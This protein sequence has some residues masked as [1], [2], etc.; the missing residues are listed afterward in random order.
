MSWLLQAGLSNAAVAALLAVGV[1]ALSRVIRNPALVH[2]MW[3]VVLLKLITPPLFELPLPIARLAPPSAVEQRAESPIAASPAA[4]SPAAASP[5]TGESA[6]QSK[7]LDVPPAA[8]PAAPP[9]DP[10]NEIGTGAS[11]VDARHL[12]S[13]AGDVVVFPSGGEVVIERPADGGDSPE[14]AARRDV[15]RA[16]S[17]APMQTLAAPPRPSPAAPQEAAQDAKAADAAFAYSI[18]ADPQWQ[19][20]LVNAIWLTGAAV[21]LLITLTRAR[22]FHWLLHRSMRDSRELA[23]D[24]SK[25]AR[26]A[27]VRRPP[28]VYLVSGAVSPMLWPLGLRPA[29]LFPAKLAESL[30]RRSRETLLLHELAHY[31]RGDHWVRLLEVLAVCLHWWN[32]LVWWVRREVHRVEEDCCDAWVIA[33]RPESRSVYARALVEAIDFLSEAAPSL[34]PTACGIGYLDSVKRRLQRIMRGRASLGLS[35]AGKLIILVFALTLAPLLPTLRSAPAEEATAAEKTAAAEE[36]PAEKK[37]DKET[38][39]TDGSSPP[40]SRIAA[41]GG[42]SVGEA[43]EFENQAIV[44]LD[45]PA[46][47]RG[48]A[49]SPDGLVAASGGGEARTPGELVVWN[50][51]SGDEVFTLRYQRGVRS[52]AFSPDGKLL[53]AGTFNNTVELIQPATG[54]TVASLTDSSSAINSVAFSPDG[55]R[56]AAGSLDKA[57]RLY[58]TD[59]HE[60]VRTLNGHTDWVFFVAFSPDGKSLA[61]CGRDKTLRIWNLET[62]QLRRSIETGREGECTAFSPDGKMVAVALWDGAVKLYNAES[63]DV[64]ATLLYPE[65]VDAGLAATL[66]F[67]PD[68]KTLLAAGA[69]QTVKSWDLSTFEPVSEFKAHDQMVWALAVSADGSRLLTGGDDRVVKLWNAA[70]ETPLATLVRRQVVEDRPEPILAIAWSAD[71]STIATSHE[72]LTIRLRDADSGALRRVLRGHDDVASAI[73]FSPDGTTLASGAADDTVRLWNV[74]TGELVRKLEGHTNWVFALAFSH[75]GKTLA[76]GGY[77]KTIR[78]WDAA[79]GES[80]ASL[81]GHDAAV[82]SLSFSP[83]DK[84]L[85][86]GSSDRSV[87]LWDLASKKEIGKLLGHEGAVRGVAFSP[88][89]TLLASGS[90]DKTVKLWNPGTKAEVRSLTGHGDMVW[91]LA[92]SAGGSTLASGGF[93]NEIKLWDPAT[94]ALRQTLRGHSEVVASLSFAPDT[95]ALASA[96]YD[97]TIRL[98]KSKGPPLPVA[99]ALAMIHG[100]GNRLLTIAMSPDA[101]LLAAAGQDKTVMLRDLRSGK[102]LK[103][104]AGLNAPISDIE[105]SPDGRTLAV[106]TYGTKLNLSLW[107]VETS[108]KRCDLLGHSEGVRQVVFSSDGK[109]LASCGWDKTARIWDLKTQKSLHATPEQSLP[110][111]GVAFSPDGETF[112]T[113]TGNWKEW[114]TPGEVKLWETKTGRELRTLGSHPHEVKGVFFEKTGNH[115]VSFGSGAT[116]RWD[117][118]TNEEATRL[119]AGRTITAVASFPD[120]RQAAF[121]DTTGAITVFD[122][123]TGKATLQYAG[124]TELVFAVAC[125]ADGSLLASL[126]RDGSIRLWPTAPKGSLLDLHAGRYVVDAA[127]SPDGESVLC[128]GTGYIK[129]FDLSSGSLIREFDAPQGVKH[130]GIAFTPNG[131]RAVSCGSDRMVRVWDVASGGELRQLT[132]HS[133]ELRCVA[134]SPDGSQAATGGFDKSIVIWDLNAGRLL[135]RLEGHRRSIWSIA[136]SPDGK[137]IASGGQLDA[138]LWDVDTGNSLKTISVGSQM[139]AITFSAD[140]ESL[141]T[142]QNNAALAQWDVETGELIW[143]KTAHTARITGACATPDGRHL[144][145][146]GLDGAVYKWDLRDDA[147]PIRLATHSA[148]SPEKNRVTALALSPDAVSIVTAGADGMVRRWN[149]DRE[150]SDSSAD[151]VRQ[152]RVPGLTPTAK[153]VLRRTLTPSFEQVWCATFSPDGKRLAVG[154][155]NKERRVLLYDAHT[156]KD[157]VSIDV[158]HDLVMCSAFSPDGRRL[159]IGS[160]AALKLWNVERRELEA[161]LK[162]HTKSIR[163][164]SFSPDGRRV[165]TAGDD[166]KTIV[167]NAAEGKQ[168]LSISSQDGLAFYCVAYS[169]D[170]RMLATGGGDWKTRQKTAVKLWDAETGRLLKTLPDSEEVTNGLAFSPDG[171]LLAARAADLA[172]ALWNVD[173]GQQVTKFDRLRG[174]RSIMFS[175]DAQRLVASS[176]TDSGIITV[177]DPDTSHLIAQVDAHDANIFSIAFSPDGQ[178][179]ATASADGT[180]KLWSIEQDSQEEETTTP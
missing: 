141:F 50:L 129:L 10:P 177:I 109:R 117:L 48:V 168:L 70:E 62:G 3:V 63:G 100:E 114:R 33:Q 147:S 78:L 169:P 68:G 84:T 133:D 12:T 89:G 155:R 87:R 157:P 44:L 17:Q 26:A 41:R 88:D 158:G 128:S 115:L 74:D 138:M 46:Q 137:L 76:S 80:L 105:F 47:I 31:R 167:W 134:V 90:E 140:G 178:T 123:E 38:E 171:K 49:L 56:L 146:G 14:G 4:A 18:L 19:L 180:A 176:S 65:R 152:W 148:E 13:P 1:F 112:A 96:G 35:G 102:M 15:A 9:A 139:S 121:G 154:G 69:N 104:I 110:I 175:P 122:F 58:N 130:T 97:R 5:A 42:F 22:R 8:P 125:S 111:S 55:S 39:K 81:A 118:A 132:G 2:G 145:T 82:R 126:S 53:A 173:S 142:G 85:A 160:G 106:G 23:W 71:G 143:R 163:M 83:D 103:T 21:M 174:T 149:L 156:L 52:V 43:Y 72:D 151:L 20:T 34:P 95:S 179:L 166:G 119:F 64:I 67:T 150:L 98:W 59:T 91:C 93:D 7:S 16:Q 11:P 6:L 57:I 99:S 108:E 37:T 120:G 136:Y 36:S 170:G 92:F 79:S 86:S 66:A 161:T 101:T 28:R 60:L 51:E 135:R 131:R 162:G 54:E 164:I 159:A 61:S 165:A 73:A 29:I 116:R 127:V 30:D 124:H 45:E 24:V 107:D 94:G 77:D 144:L 153:L 27:G 113:S 172:I 40:A 32:P 25:L 75:D